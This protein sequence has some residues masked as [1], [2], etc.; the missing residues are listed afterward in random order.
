M[1]TTK[2]NSATRRAQEGYTKKDQ[3]MKN[4]TSDLKGWYRDHKNKNSIKHCKISL[5]NCAMGLTK[6]EID[7]GAPRRDNVLLTMLVSR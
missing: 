7:D 3:S 4:P 2:T 1:R 5:A 6:E